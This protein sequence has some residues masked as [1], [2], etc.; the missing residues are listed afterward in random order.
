MA[1]SIRDMSMNL[2]LAG[3][4]GNVLQDTVQ[5]MGANGISS[6]EFASRLKAQIP[7]VAGETVDPLLMQNKQISGVSRCQYVLRNLQQLASTGLS[8]NDIWFSPPATVSDSDAASLIAGNYE[9]VLMRNP[10]V[11]NILATA[12]TQFNSMSDPN[13]ATQYTVPQLKAAEDKSVIQVHQALHDWVVNNVYLDKFN[14]AGLPAGNP[15]SPPIPLVYSSGFDQTWANLQEGASAVS[16]NLKTYGDTVWEESIVPISQKLSP[17]GWMMSIAT[18][19]NSFLQ[20]LCVPTILWILGSLLSLV[21]EVS[22]FL[23]WFAYPF[24]FLTMGRHAY[25]GML[26]LLV[27]ASLSIAAFRLI[28]FFYDALMAWIFTYLSLAI[29]AISSV[30]G[31]ALGFEAGPVGSALGVV[32]MSTFM[33]TLFTFL[34]VIIYVV[35]LFYLGIK[36]IPMVT[37]FLGGESPLGAAA[38][39]IQT[40]VS[41]GQSIASTAASTAMTSAMPAL[42][43]KAL[44]AL[45][46]AGGRAGSVLS[47]GKQT[48]MGAFS[49]LKSSVGQYGRIKPRS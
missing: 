32:T 45:M 31:A 39:S 30:G 48:A 16:N 4:Q 18:K 24:S 40:G 21:L 15:L 17:E 35:A 43:A 22:V 3:T 42:G 6:M 49:A 20:T 47:A 34:Y 19:L 37:K 8:S 14:A 12:L 44:P 38:Q 27:V 2:I 10:D 25:T 26:K 46:S 5:N 1:C 41:A 13:S 33:M 28:C 36:T 11:L 29:V 23:C 7:K 9:K